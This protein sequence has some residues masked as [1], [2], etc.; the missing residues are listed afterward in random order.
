MSTKTTCGE[1][2]FFLSLLWYIFMDF[3]IKLLWNKCESWNITQTNQMLAMNW[4]VAEVF[5][6]R[7]K[8]K[9]KGVRVFKS[10]MCQISIPTARVGSMIYQVCLMSSLPN[11][12]PSWPPYFF[13]CCILLR[14]YHELVRS[15]LLGWPRRV[16]L[17][18]WLGL[19]R[20]G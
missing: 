17:G 3:F 2:N 6:C 16:R 18:G 9:M 10:V 5:K 12:F 14:F 7:W 11:A 15:S 20:L 4:K 8:S 1:F 19:V 13:S